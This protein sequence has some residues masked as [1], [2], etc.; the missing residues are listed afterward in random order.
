MDGE[1][2][3]ERKAVYQLM[4][5]VLQK[6]RVKW[7]GTLS[8]PF[9]ILEWTWGT[10]GS[11]VMKEQR[12]N[13]EVLW[14]TLKFQN[15]TVSTSALAAFLKWVS[16][17]VPEFQKAA[18]SFDGAVWDRIGL[19]L[20]DAATCS[21]T[22]VQR[23]S[24]PWRTVFETLEKHTGSAA[25]VQ[26][27]APP[28][29]ATLNNRRDGSDN[30]LDRGPRNLEK[31][32]DPS[33][34]DK[35]AAKLLPVWR[36]ISETLTKIR[37]GRANS[38]DHSP[39]TPRHPAAASRCGKQLRSDPIRD[40]N[41]SSGRGEGKWRPPESGAAA[42]AGRRRQPRGRGPL[43]IVAAPWLPTA[44]PPVLAATQS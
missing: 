42:A 32:P 40:F 10:M 1:M 30:P 39:R 23:L 8:H 43:W 14:R 18:F 6:H 16:K 24:G 2:S 36:K 26:S 13:P 22:V 5:G 3:K 38:S 44:P 21:D 33:P 41:P 7:D 25:S 37:R 28:S 9:L 29:S 15:R 27:A 4:E 11:S 34:A 19:R 12:V 31:E 17:N 20:R 35:T